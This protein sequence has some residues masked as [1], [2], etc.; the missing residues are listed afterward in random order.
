MLSKE[1]T[2]WCYNISQED[3]WLD[4]DRKVVMGKTLRHCIKLIHCNLL[5]NKCSKILGGIEIVRGYSA[6]QTNLTISGL[7]MNSASRSI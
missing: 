4:K 5:L 2:R 3:V 6:R 7:K 1:K